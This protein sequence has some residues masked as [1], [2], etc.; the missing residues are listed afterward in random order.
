MCVMLCL[1]SALS[2]RV[3]ALQISIVIIII[4]VATLSV[5]VSGLNPERLHVMNRLSNWA[6]GWVRLLS[7][8]AKRS[9]SASRKSCR[10]DTSDP[11]ISIVFLIY[12]FF[13]CFVYHCSESS[14]PCVWAHTCLCMRPGVFI[15]RLVLAEGLKH[16]ASEVR[17]TLSPAWS[18]F[19]ACSFHS[20][21]LSWSLGIWPGG[22]HPKH[23]PWVLFES[24]MFADEDGVWVVRR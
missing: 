24:A 6:A 5:A 19:V 1:F 8:V 4:K 13:N 18:A 20:L 3:D 7:H 16:Q 10:F 22:F 9:S 2:S 17:I 12:I 23:R 15:S 14:F 11:L 21:H